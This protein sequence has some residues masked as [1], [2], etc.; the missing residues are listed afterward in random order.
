[1]T[2]KAKFPYK[3][4]LSKVKVKTNRTRSTKGTYYKEWSFANNFFIF[5]KMEKELT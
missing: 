2:E 4:S 5:K 1:M 3:T